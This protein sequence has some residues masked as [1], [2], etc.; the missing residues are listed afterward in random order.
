MRIN[1]CSLV[2][3]LLLSLLQ[4]KSCSLTNSNLHKTFAFMWPF[5][6]SI[7]WNTKLAVSDPPLHWLLSQVQ[8]TPQQQLQE[9]R[10]PW[11]GPRSCSLHQDGFVPS[12]KAQGQSEKFALPSSHWHKGLAKERFEFPLLSTRT[13]SQ[14]LWKQDRDCCSLCSLYSGTVHFWIR[15]Y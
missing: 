1:I 9:R 8:Q 12:A 2:L 11:D 13:L 4:N 5:L 14:A 7:A 6:C 15:G 3:Y 10:Q